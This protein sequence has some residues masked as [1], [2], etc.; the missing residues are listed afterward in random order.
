M[1]TLNA[2]EN[3]DNLHKCDNDWGRGQ[4]MR[5]CFADVMYDWSPRRKEKATGC[6]CAMCC[7]R[8]DWRPKRRKEGGGERGSLPSSAELS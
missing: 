7:W 2:D 4:K 6:E 1:G 5:K 8:G 3:T